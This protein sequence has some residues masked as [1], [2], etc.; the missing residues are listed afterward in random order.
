MHLNDKFT[1]QYQKE[2]NKEDNQHVSIMSV[3]AYHESVEVT[4][5]ERVS[6]LARV[7][8]ISHLTPRKSI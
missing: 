3:I 5:Q 8:V 6:V 1:C 2:M 4:E 7:E